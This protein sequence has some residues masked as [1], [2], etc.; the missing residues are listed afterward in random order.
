MRYDMGKCVIERPR[1][2]SGA[3]SAKARWYGKFYWDEDG[4]DYDGH[5]HLPVSS[6][7]EGYHKRIGSKSFSDV[8]GPIEGYLKSSV[9]RPWNDV[10][11]ELSKGLG[12]FSWPLRHILEQHIDVAVK[13][14]RGIDGNIWHLGHSGPEIVDGIR[15]GTE[16]YVEPKTGILRRHPE[17]GK[18]WRTR[19]KPVPELRMVEA[20]PERW[21]VLIN[22]LWFLGKYEE[23]PASVNSR[24]PA[25]LGTHYFKPE[26]PDIEG[27][28]GTIKVFRKLKSCSK[29]EIRD[30]RERLKRA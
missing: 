5:T 11:S 19:H 27:T 24:Y 29:K 23:G 8:L 12:Q 16:F 9:G 25:Y 6:K 15:Y 1:R 10:F 4:L 30:I 26:W 14:Y 17:A 22:G 28:R 3:R 7:Q 20:D 21:Y 18:G 13:T 2:N